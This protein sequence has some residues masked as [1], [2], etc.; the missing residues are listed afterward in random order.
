MPGAHRSALGE[1]P[2]TRVARMPFVPVTTSADRAHVGD[3]LAG[4][5]RLVDGDQRAGYRQRRRR[6]QRAATPP[7]ATPGRGIAAQVPGQ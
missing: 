7:L 3:A 6:A 1:G 2:L 5:E 4:S